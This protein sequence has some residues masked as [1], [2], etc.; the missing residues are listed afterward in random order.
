MTP[1]QRAI[2]N[3]TISLLS[4]VVVI[5]LVLNA[6]DAVAS[7]SAEPT[8]LSSVAGVDRPGPWLVRA[9]SSLVGMRDNWLGM[10]G[11]ELGL[12]VGRDL[13]AGF[14]VELTGSA[15]E[16]D[17]DYRRSWSTMAALRG[18][19]AAT[20]NGRHAFTVAG[21]PFV[22]VGNVVHGTVPFAHGE[23][24]YVYRAPFGLT[25]LGG[26]GLNMAL[27]S[28]PYVTPT[29]EPC[30]DSGGD[31]I[32]FCIDLGPDA[33]EMHTGDTNLHLRLAVGWQF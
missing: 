32:T 11:L 13:G 17:G 3:K 29:T 28:S 31:A 27:A 5:P 23:L 1:G 12:T 30:D 9:E 16:A 15:R 18:V 2:V 26:G 6:A 22:E 24:A 10:P 14:S 33:Q 25:V 8:T 19:V 20:A 7:T 4:A 21:G